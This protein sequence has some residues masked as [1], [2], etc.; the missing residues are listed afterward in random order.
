[1]SSRQHHHRWYHTCKVERCLASMSCRPTTARQKPGWRLPPL[2]RLNSNT[3]VVL[4]RAQ[5]RH[6]TA[7]CR[8]PGCRRAATAAR[9]RRLAAAR[10]PC[11]HKTAATQR[12][13]G[14]PDDPT[15]RSSSCCPF[16]PNVYETASISESRLVHRTTMIGHSPKLPEGHV[17]RYVQW[18]KRTCNCSVA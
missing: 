15:R 16:H 1:M 17:D 11:T 9:Q 13:A 7:A 10:P 2:P 18:F 3:P 4:C 12:R 5:C 8:P 14:R 6:Y